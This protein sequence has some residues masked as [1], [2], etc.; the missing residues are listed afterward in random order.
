MSART[1]TV[2]ANGLVFTYDECG[3]GDDVALLLHGFPECRMSWRHQLPA[4]AAQGWRAVAPDLRG[5]G[6][7][8]RPAERSA[9]RLPLLLDDVAALF[10]ALGAR[11]R[12]LI[13]HDWGALIAWSFA[14]RRIRPL[15]GLIVM[16]VPHPD[17][18]WHVLTH[19]WRQRL[20]SWY[21]VFFQLPRLPELAM[22]AGGARAVQRAF[23]RMSRN[24]AAFP[25]DVLAR[26]RDNAL[27]PGAMTAM[28]NYYRA[29]FGTMMATKRRSPPIVVPVL[30][31]WGEHDTALG[32]ELTEGYGGL[33]DDFT[34][35]RLPDASH[36]VQQDAPDA[37]NAA[38]AAWLGRTGL[39]AEPPR[40]I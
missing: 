30:M 3:G 32:I 34:L 24:P 31:V 26:Y 10:D 7:T 17:V 38:L 25:P 2:R 6:D 36:W 37:V 21:V 22:T 12:L 33:V 28:L 1:G 18:F 15:D 5:Y 16:N 23:T 35:V 8:S 27:A 4:L 9:Y 11:R 40:A 20:R 29:N 19:S 14:I 13:G 39:A